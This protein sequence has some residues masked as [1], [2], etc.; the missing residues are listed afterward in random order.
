MTEQNTTRC[1]GLNL[2]SV[3]SDVVSTVY[4][5]RST[6]SR[7]SF[8]AN[9]QTNKHMYLLLGLHTTQLSIEAFQFHFG[10]RRVHL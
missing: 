7:F 8:Q 4:H 3:D 10:W 9:K 1:I 2:F 5:R 6:E